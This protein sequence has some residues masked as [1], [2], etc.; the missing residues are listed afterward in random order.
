MSNG[1]FLTV[2]GRWKHHVQ[3]S[4]IDRSLTRR[5]QALAMLMFYA[6]FSAALDATMEVA[7]FDEQEAVQ[8]LQALRTEIQQVEA[9][10]SHLLSGKRCS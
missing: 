1:T 8:L 7:E 6:G 4:K 10:A 3:A 5:E 2:A 9:M